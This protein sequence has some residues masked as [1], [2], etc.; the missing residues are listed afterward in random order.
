MKIKYVTIFILTKSKSSI[1]I[2]IE[3]IIEKI[4]VSLARHLGLDAKD[5]ADDVL[6]LEDLGANSLDV[7]EIAMAVEDELG[8]VIPD[9]D[10]V[11]LR[12][13]KDVADYIESNM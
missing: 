3:I 7:V 6:I 13:I 12:T 2:F 1:I 4:K 10:I 5:I 8:I 9:E 11:N